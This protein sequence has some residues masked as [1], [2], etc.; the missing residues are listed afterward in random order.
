MSAKKPSIFNKIH[1][2]ALN[3]N[4]GNG[5]S[6]ITYNE[7]DDSC[8]VYIYYQELKLFHEYKTKYSLLKL[9]YFMLEVIESEIGIKE[10]SGTYIHFKDLNGEV[11][12]SK[13]Y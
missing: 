9:F 7:I 11:K 12:Y 4:W 13:I 6:S 3:R 5:M 8:A 2:L 10:L 1:S